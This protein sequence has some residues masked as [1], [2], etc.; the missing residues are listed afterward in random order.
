L[1][2]LLVRKWKPDFG[3]NND[4]D[5]SHRSEATDGDRENLN[6]NSNGQEPIKDNIVMVKF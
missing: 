2:F 3:K 6:S 5:S 1:L 4:A